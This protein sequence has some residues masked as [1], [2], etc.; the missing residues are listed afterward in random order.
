[1]I[2][3]DMHT[4]SNNSFDAKNSVDEMCRSAIER[5]L[6]ALAVTDH[7]EAPFIRFGADCEFGCFDEQIPKSIADINSAKEKYKDSLKV[8][9]G[10]ELGELISTICLSD[11]SMS[12]RKP[13]NFRTLTALRTLLI[14]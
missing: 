2:L 9:C 13:L 12:L 8:L 1:M 7:C 3:C 10:M 14:H 5:G 11:I 4:H 6:Y